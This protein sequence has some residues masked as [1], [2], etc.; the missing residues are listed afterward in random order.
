MAKQT[1]RKRIPAYKRQKKRYLLKLGIFLLVIF[2]FTF[3]ISLISRSLVK[4][5]S[6]LSGEI[7]TMQDKLTAEEDRTQSLREYEAYTQTKA[8]AEEMAS[9]KLGFVHEGEIIFRAND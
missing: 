9:E 1:S 8:F 5:R 2:A 7:A 3:Y 6:R 4:E